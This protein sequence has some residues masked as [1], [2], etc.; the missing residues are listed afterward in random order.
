MKGTRNHGKRSGAVVAEAKTKKTRSRKLT[1][2]LY[3][4]CV[5][6]K[7]NIAETVAEAV[8]NF[9]SFP[10]ESKPKLSC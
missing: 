6:R 5:S 4:K 8:N 7:L 3:V 10:K 9:L 1:E 2:G